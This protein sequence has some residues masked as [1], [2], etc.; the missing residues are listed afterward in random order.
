MA[1]L[2]HIWYYTHLKGKNMD[3]QMVAF[4]GGQVEIGIPSQYVGPVE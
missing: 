3:G 2:Q 4:P 1:D